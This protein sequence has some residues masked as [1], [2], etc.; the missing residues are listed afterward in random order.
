MNM[1]KFYLTLATVILLGA[2]GKSSNSTPAASAAS[3]RFPHAA[4]KKAAS[5]ASDQWITDNGAKTNTLPVAVS[6]SPAATS[7]PPPD[8][9]AAS[10]A[11]AANTKLAPA[12]EALIKRM[13]QCY[14][15]LPA[16]SSADMKAT[17]ADVR[18]SLAGTDGDTCRGTMNEDFNST[19]AALGCE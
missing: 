10:S 8:A 18:T 6:A 17:L 13:T 1:N 3:A 16:E 5:A 2:C 9:P 7:A 14:D 4:A 15:R 12:C 11:P 19:A